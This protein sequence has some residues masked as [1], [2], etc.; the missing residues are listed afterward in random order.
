[1]EETCY[2]ERDPRCLVV[3]GICLFISAPLLCRAQE[4]D[5]VAFRNAGETE[6]APIVVSA[7]RIPIPEENS[8]ATISVIPA[9]DLEQKQIERV[10]DAL[11]EVPGLVSRADGSARSAHFGFYARF[12]QRAHA[13]AARWHSDQSRFA[14]RIQFCRSDDGRYRSNRN[15]ARPAEHTLRPARARRCDP[16]FHQAGKWNARRSR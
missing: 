4:A 7:T 3:V 9:E 8:P 2:V 13:G 12:A 6:N 1:M 10:A 15:R 11:R 5:S 14:G 16:A